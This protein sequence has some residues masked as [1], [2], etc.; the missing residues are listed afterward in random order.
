L[1]PQKQES[2]EIALNLTPE[3]LGEW[4]QHPSTKEVLR[5][6]REIREDYREQMALGMTLNLNSTENT[7][8]MTSR[9]S[10]VIYALDLTLAIRSHSEDEI[11]VKTGY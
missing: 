7:A 6:L 3:A 5:F 9:L 2:R 10:G 4:K 8:L 1:P 11:D